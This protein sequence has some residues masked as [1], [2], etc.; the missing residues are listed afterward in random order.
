MTTEALHP[1]VKQEN[2]EAGS[3]ALVSRLNLIWRAAILSTFIVGVLLRWTGLSAQSLWAD[4]GFT[5]WFSQFSPLTQWRLLRW[6]NSAPSYY[7]LL[8][9]WIPLWGTSETAFRA[10]SALFGSLSLAVFYLVAR[11]MWPSRVFVFLGLALYSVSFFQIWYAKEAR[12]YA[13]F[14]FFLFTSV[15]CVQLYLEKPGTLR[16]ICLALAVS[17]SL[18]THNMAL[19]YL[20][21]VVLFWFIYP[22]VLTFRDRLKKAAIAALSVALLY[23]PWVPVLIQQVRAVHGYFWAPKPTFADIASSLCT[24]CGIDPYALR[25]VRYYVHPPHLFGLWFWIGL[26]LLVL[27]LCI[28]SAWRVPLTSDCRKSLALQIYALLPVVLVFGWSRV[29][30]SV[31]VDRNLIGVSAFLPLVI[32]APT[33]LFAGKKKRFFEAV[34]CCVLCAAL[35]SLCLHQQSKDNWRGVTRY[36]LNLPERQRA[37]FVFQPFCQ[38]LVHYYATGW[39]KMYPHEPEIRGL[40]TD[41]NV[42]PTGPGI[43]PKLQSADLNSMLDN[44]FKSE[45]YKE[46]D[47]ALQAE[48]LSPNVQAIPAY[49]KGHCASVVNEEFGNLAV[50][51]CF[52]LSK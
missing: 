34:G 9:Y 49:L 44:A 19:Y 38:I 37:V 7:V 18:Y 29:S 20:P 24:F 28:V 36:V 1:A 40:V 47:I 6:D 51:R 48:R 13:L 32:C 11:K 27:A 30:T 52:I 39:A 10:L 42:A 31:Y 50:E 14:S 23:A 41:F 8:H 26:T 16:F 43:L 15:Y 25:E 33:A 21:G 35:I 2:P 22:S 45:Q 4:E 17:A 12:C 5:T 3:K 46:I